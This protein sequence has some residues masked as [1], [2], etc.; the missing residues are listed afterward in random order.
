L[1]NTEKNVKKELILKH[2]KFN[3]NANPKISI[4]S[5]A[6][7][8]GPYILRFLRS[9]QN[10]LLDEIEIIFIDDYSTDNTIKIIEKCQKEDNRIILIKHNINKGTL[11][12]RNDGAIISRGE[13]L[14]FPDPDDILSND[15]LKYC[16]NKA[17]KENY[18]MIRFNLYGGK[19]MGVLNFGEIKTQKVYQPELSYYIFYNK[20]YLKQTDYSISNKFIK[21]NI[22]IKALNSINNYYLNQNMIVYEDGLINF[23]LYKFAKSLYYS[24]KIGYFYLK[25]N[26]S[27]T[28]NFKRDIER[29]I[30]NCYLYLKFIFENTKNNQYEKNIASTIYKNVH[31]EI[32][33]ISHFEKLTKEYNFYY[34]VINLYLYNDFIPTLIKEELKNITKLIKKTEKNKYL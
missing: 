18:D 34:N 25:N 33:N 30:K 28:N 23:K 3:K 15:I 27:I 31:L 29:T 9:I 17:N 22:F 24:K 5:A 11:I 12:S 4:I 21:R 2:N 6:Y 1:K 7:N 8:R 20:G 13:Y 32:S 26:H 19:E 14:I 16:Y 10:Q